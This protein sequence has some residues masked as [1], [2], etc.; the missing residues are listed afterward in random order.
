MDS[1]FGFF[2][3]LLLKNVGKRIGEDFEGGGGDTV[4]LEGSGGE[5]EAAEEEG[6]AVSSSSESSAPWTCSMY[7]SKALSIRDAS[8]FP[9]DK[10]E[11]MMMRD[12]QWSNGGG[13]G[14]GGNRLVPSHILAW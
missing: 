5:T 9:R 13:G 10:R 4:L 14:G 2:F 11:K 8:T 12:H 1:D 7:L 6:G 3:F